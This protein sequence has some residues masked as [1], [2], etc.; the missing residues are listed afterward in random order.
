VKVHLKID[1]Y[2]EVEHPFLPEN[3]DVLDLIE[4]GVRMLKA[5]RIY[6]GAKLSMI[7]A[8]K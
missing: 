7:R 1:C 5:K 2:I 3:V 4:G 8:S 6:P